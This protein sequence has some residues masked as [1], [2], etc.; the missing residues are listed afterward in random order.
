MSFSNAGNVWVW[1]RM[2]LYGRHGGQVRQAT[3]HLEDADAWILKYGSRKAA[4]EQ[5]APEPA[6][7]TKAAPQPATNGT[8]DAV[9]AARAKWGRVH[10]DAFHA[11]RDALRKGWIL[12]GGVPT[13]ADA[14]ND[15]A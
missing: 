9:R 13:W 12:V 15:R 6:A 1:D 7:T 14:L 8:A 3:P 5:P 2:G 10:P 4:A 11:K